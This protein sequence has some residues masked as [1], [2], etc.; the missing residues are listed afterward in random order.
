MPSMWQ[1]HVTPYRM[2]R[3]FKSPRKTEPVHTA[4]RW[5]WVYL[6][7]YLLWSRW[8]RTH[9][10]NQWL[11]TSLRRCHMGTQ[12]PWELLLDSAG[13]CLQLFSRLPGFIR[14]QIDELNRDVVG[15][16]LCILEI[17]KGDL[18]LTISKMWFCFW[19]TILARGVASWGK[20]VKLRSG[21]WLWKPR[22][23]M[24][25]WKYLGRHL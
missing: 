13:S 11:N 15:T 1:I 4:L 9:S 7:P 20:A 16:H 6:S 12:P 24:R 25:A 2:L 8:K 19:L 23:L 10:P 22:T 14:D 5:N 17:L 3:K 21:Y 18:I